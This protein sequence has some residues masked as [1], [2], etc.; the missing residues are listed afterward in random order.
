MPEPAPVTM[1]VLFEN[2]MLPHS[3]LAIGKSFERCKQSNTLMKEI[4]TEVVVAA[5]VSSK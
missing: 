4:V 5:E 2:R 1:H 3:R